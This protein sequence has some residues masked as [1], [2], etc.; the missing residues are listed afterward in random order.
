V[1]AGLPEWTGCYN[2]HMG[3]LAFMAC[4]ALLVLAGVARPQDAPTVPRLLERM[5]A[6]NYLSRRGAVWATKGRKEQA[7]RDALLRLAQEDPHADVRGAAFFAFASVEED[8][9]VP[10]LL[11]IARARKFAGPR[12]PMYDV[13]GDLGDLRAVPVLLD[14]LEEDTAWA[15]RAAVALGKLRVAKAF[16]PL[17]RFYV[18]HAGDPNAAADVPPA[19]LAIAPKRGFYFLLSRFKYG[20]PT[21]RRNL[22]PHLRRGR[23][24]RVQAV[25]LEYLKVFDQDLRQSAIRVLGAVGDG[26]AVPKLGEHVRK[27][28]EDLAV[29]AVALG[30][31]GDPEGARI[32]S[33]WLSLPE[34]DDHERIVIAWGLA[35][36]PD[37]DGLGPLLAALGREIHLPAKVQMVEA[38]ARL[39]DTRA[40]AD[41]AGMVDDPGFSA[42]TRRSIDPLVFPYNV[43]VGTIALWAIRTILDEKSPIPLADLKVDPKAQQPLLWFESERVRFQAWWKTH[44]NDEAFRY[45]R[46][47]D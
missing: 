3:K 29:T 40:V 18:N 9:V 11:K 1:G 26:K 17:C 16:E 41:L 25:M 42:Q 2:S 31:I 39:G 14:G 22:V 33:R 44:H 36:T 8:R 34:L 43:H 30:E 6:D 5:K 15:V 28:P 13:L 20:G 24:T 38:L 37:P 35:R 10:C 27:K 46:G 47:E 19:I 23:S 45:E 7:L 21:A 12:G 4:V 32:L